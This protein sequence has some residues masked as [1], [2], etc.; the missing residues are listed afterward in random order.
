MDGLVELL[1][2]GVG[3]TVLRQGDLFAADDAAETP[4]LDIP[5]YPPSPQRWDVPVH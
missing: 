5:T 3:R 2:R 1:G 4:L